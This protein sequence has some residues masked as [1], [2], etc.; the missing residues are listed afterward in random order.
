MT[1]KKST[2]KKS[3]TLRSHVSSHRDSP[4][5]KEGGFSLYQE[6]SQPSYQ[7]ALDWMRTLEAP[8]ITLDFWARGNY[9]RRLIY[10][11]SRAIEPLIIPVTYV[12][13]MRWAY[14]RL[15]LVGLPVEFLYCGRTSDPQ[16]VLHLCPYDIQFDSGW[17]Y[18]G[19]LGSQAQIRGKDWFP[20][21]GRACLMPETVVEWLV[22]EAAD[23]F[24]EGKVFIAPADLIGIN[25][26]RILNGVQ[27]LS[28]VTGGLP[29]TEQHQIAQAI[30][31]L[32]IPFLDNMSN[33]DIRTFLKDFEGD[34]VNFR[35]AFQDLVVAR[36]KSAEAISFY[37][38]RLRGE[39]AELMKAEKYHPLRS[40]V[41]KL[42]GVLTFADTSLSIAESVQHAGITSSVALGV[43]AA[44]VTL[45]DL[46]KQFSERQ[47][48]MSE[49]PFFV[50]WKLGITRPSQVKEVRSVEISK[51]PKM[52]IPQA[53]FK[54]GFHWLCPPTSGLSFLGVG[55]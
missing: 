22:N 10:N 33:A 20:V 32:D 7:V 45:F 50:L 51:V 46:W 36:G 4:E 31:Q 15:A 8:H 18:V 5:Y 21:L 14:R 26:K 12:D 6:V 43:G 2:H 42:G 40:G 48:R 39:I 9:T 53:D 34:L 3:K 28:D 37:V 38:E 13:E 44:A 25:S 17:G 11:R 29:I 1:K 55:K 27:A 52:K 23:D 49:N 41:S 30:L 35:H 24:L 54:E 16:K 47:R 19:A